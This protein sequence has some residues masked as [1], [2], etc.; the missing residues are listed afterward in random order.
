VLLAAQLELGCR[1]EAPRLD[2]RTVRI[3]NRAVGFDPPVICWREC[4]IGA[5]YELQQLPRRVDVSEARTEG[6]VVELALE[7]C[8]QVD[9]RRLDDEIVVPACPEAPRTLRRRAMC[10]AKQLP[11]V[12]TLV[13]RPI[14]NFQ[15]TTG[16]TSLR[17]TSEIDLR[18]KAVGGCM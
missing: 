3:D 1:R 4:A 7:V 2:I 12:A 5:L 17:A 18:Q 15:P 10:W 11:A 14:F 13:S 9:R 16:S 6:A 8:I